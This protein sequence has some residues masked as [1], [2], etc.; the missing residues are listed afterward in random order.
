MGGMKVKE[1]K[2]GGMEVVGGGAHV[3]MQSLKLERMLPGERDAMRGWMK[4]G[5]D[6]LQRE[7]ISG[8]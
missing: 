1:M 7:T 8:S 5:T 4:E 2:V 3:S 6:L